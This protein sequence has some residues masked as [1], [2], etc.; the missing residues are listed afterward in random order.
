M[1]NA[2]HRLGPPARASLRQRLIDTTTLPS[3]RCNQYPPRHSD[4]GRQLGGREIPERRYELNRLYFILSRLTLP[5]G[6]GSKHRKASSPQGCYMIR[7]LLVIGAV[8]AAAIGA[9]PTAGAGPEDQ[10]RS[11]LP[12]GYGPAACQ[13][14]NNPPTPAGAPQWMHAQVAALECRDNFL[15]GGPTYAYYRLYANHDMLHE[16][17]SGEKDASRQRT[18][19]SCRA[20]AGREPVP[21]PRGPGMTIAPLTRWPAGWHAARFT[22]RCM[23]TPVQSPSCGRR[24]PT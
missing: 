4:I 21:R 8:A 7:E 18:G 13:P 22:D 23:E 12:A 5:N 16:A 2:A 6:P 24:T 11:L 3:L 1:A 15:P 20:P 9:A 14:P 10:L 19:G 17:F